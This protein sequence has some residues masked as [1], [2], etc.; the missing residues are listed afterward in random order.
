M[1]MTGNYL[2]QA[3][4]AKDYFLT[5]DHQ[6]LA[7][8]L[9]VPLDGGYLFVTFLHSP[10]RIC[11]ATGDLERQTPAGWVPADSYEETMTLLDLV[12]DS[13]DDRSLT[14]RWKT[15]ESFGH[16]FHRSLLEEQRN[17]VAQRFDEY[18]EGLRRACQALGGRVLPGCDIGYAIALFDGLEIGLQFWH[19][20]EEFLPRIRFLWD[21]NANQYLRYETM[22]FA[23]RLLL[24]RLCTLAAPGGD[25]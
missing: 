7:R 23:V 4:R 13:R 5:Y 8:K 17:P 24:T 22:Y 19:G 20:D 12:C 21:E 10:Y 14:G 9:G 2:I 25:L 16:A 6:A 15:M 3:Q 18:P 1:A 11:L